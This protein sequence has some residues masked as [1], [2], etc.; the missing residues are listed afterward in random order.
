MGNWVKEACDSSALLYIRIQRSQNKSLHL[1]SKYNYTQTGFSILSLLTK[2]N[3][4]KFENKVF[5]AWRL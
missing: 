2:L 3:E 4:A 5:A 1:F